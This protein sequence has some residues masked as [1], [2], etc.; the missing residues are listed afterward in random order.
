MEGR[1]TF[2]IFEQKFLTRSYVMVV[3]C[4]C[5]NNKLKLWYNLIQF[6][7]NNDL[8]S[9]SRRRCFAKYSTFVLKPG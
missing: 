8:M 1:E 5:F 4:K 9:S 6:C 7:C 2:F 3:T